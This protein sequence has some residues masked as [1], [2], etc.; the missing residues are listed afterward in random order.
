MSGTPYLFRRGN[1]FSFRIAI[2]ADLRDIFQC[3]EVVRSLKTERRAEA[4]P[5]ALKM[6][7]EALILF[8]EARTMDMTEKRRIQA[9]RDKLSLKEQMHN[10]EL[11][12]IEVDRRL[13]ILKTKAETV[14]KTENEILKSVVQSRGERSVVQSGGAGDSVTSKSKAPL[15]SAVINEFVAEYDP[16]KKAMLG[17]HRTNLPRLLD[18]ISDKH[19]DE[20][21]HIDLSRHCADYCKQAHLKTFKS[22]KSSISQLIDW[23]RARYER[24][25]DN[26]DMRSIKYS[27]SRDEPE[28]KQRAF[29]DTE[30]VKLFTCEEMQEH[31]KNGKGVHKFWLPVVG[32]FT[33]ARV[34]EICQINPQK[35]VILDDSGVL[36][37][38]INNDG[39]GKSV[40]TAAGVR[41]VPVH[42]RLIE[43]GFLDYVESV[44]KAGHTRLFPQWAQKKG[45]KAGDSAGHDF[46]RFLEDIGLRDSTKGRALTGMHG[47]RKTVLTHA[48]KG[49]F[50]GA[51]LPIIGH[52][53]DVLDESGNKVPA[54]SLSYVDEDALKVPLAD[55]AATIEKLSFD[56]DFVKPC[57]PIL[58]RLARKA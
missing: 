24:A 20:I 46:R 27:G 9:L 53:N 21:R 11:R 26:V 19:V 10:D 31:C 4:V 33:G 7:A 52:E 36:Y 45:A 55:K 34:S 57:A 1:R 41:V 40:K 50:L 2:P 35:D 25:F 56:I 37:L 18:S 16:T 54:V 13:E 29:K 6:A 58:S 28:G 51:I 44:R 3:R 48:Y 30:L 8:N 23:T 32:L 39:E 47:F 43:L 14:L 17:K 22:Y 5:L 15:L 49:G 38:S 12:N 42:S